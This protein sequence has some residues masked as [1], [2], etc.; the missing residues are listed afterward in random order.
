MS[1]SRYV[2]VGDD[3]RIEVVPNTKFILQ[4]ACCDCGL[5]HDILIEVNAQGMTMEI[6][7][8]NRSTGQR[9]RYMR[10]RGGI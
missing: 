7:R 3:N 5:V 9:R 8:N 10:V 6:S 4:L 1:K 2:T